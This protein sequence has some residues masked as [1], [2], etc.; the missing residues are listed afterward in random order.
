[1]NASDLQAWRSSVGLSRQ[2]AAE[3]LG[4]SLS[5]FLNQLYGHRPVSRQTER[6]AAFVQQNHAALSPGEQIIYRNPENSH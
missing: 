5:G 4:L 1:M 3:A 6:L 2:D